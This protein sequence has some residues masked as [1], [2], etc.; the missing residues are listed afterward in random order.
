MRRIMVWLLALILLPVLASCS[1]LAD[2]D[3]LHGIVQNRLDVVFQE[4]TLVIKS[5][6]RQG[7]SPLGSENGVERRI[8]YYN[9]QLAFMRDYA[10][11]D[12]QSLNP[13]SLAALLGASER[14]LSGIDPDGNQAG[15]VLTVRGS[16]SFEN[17]DG[18]QPI[19]F[20]M[21]ANAS[22][23]AASTTTPSASLDDTSANTARRLIT[24]IEGALQGPGGTDA[25]STQ[26]ISEELDAAHRRIV[27]RLD[28][29]NR[30]LIIAGG[31]ESGEYQLV[32]RTL[33]AQL[34]A[35]GVRASATPTDGSVEN[36]AL[37]ERGEADFIL[38]QNDVAAMAYRGQGLFARQPAR[39]DL[40]AVASLFP[41]PLHIIVRRDSDITSVAHLAGKRVDLG[42]PDS[43]TRATALAALAAYGLKE[44]HLLSQPGRS[45][46]Q[47]AKALENNEIDAFFAVVSAPARRLQALAAAGNSRLLS[48]HPGALDNLQA[49]QAGFVPMY[50]AAGTYPGQD[51]PVTTVAVTALLAAR[52][53]RPEADV[54]T[55][56]N[57]LF[58]ETDFLG[59]GS[60]AGALITPHNATKGLTL[61]A[62]PGALLLLSG[63]NVKGAVSSGAVL[64]E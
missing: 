29:L 18:W 64:A 27:R 34:T 24:R 62:H 12:W 38:V 45:L 55:L 32:A 61:P 58:E 11:S 44:A 14:G 60:A 15:D 43:G 17:R 37:L 30:A 1:K 8:V 4:P 10:L 63:S 52:G 39:Q 19:G 47:A 13:A 36:I 26:V 40:R 31:P 41:E 3:M 50:L 56:I 7:S 48:L 53:E 57:T 23:A 35:S 20:V 6:R 28:R 46:E 54:R 16:I 42:L 22:A 25:A 2:D 9:A 33:A 49:L 21:P 59:A 5:L 51:S